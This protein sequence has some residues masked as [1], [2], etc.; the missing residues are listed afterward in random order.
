MVILLDILIGLSLL[1]VVV[2]FFLGMIAFARNGAEAAASS[3]RLMAWRVKTQ[4]IAV[5]VLLLCAWARSQHPV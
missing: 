1:T 5:G 4:V 3:N 2:T